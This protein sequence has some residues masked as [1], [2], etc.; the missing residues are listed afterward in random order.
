MKY[1]AAL[2]IF[3]LTINNSPAQAGSCVSKTEM[4]IAKSLAGVGEC[5]GSKK[6]AFENNLWL[7]VSELT[8]RYQISKVV[9]VEDTCA[10]KVL[11]SQTFDETITETKRFLSSETFGA[12]KHYL[13]D[14]ETAMAKCEA[15][16]RSLI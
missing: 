5:A 2:I 9:T 7:G 14:I 15:Y 16:R 1:S 11:L 12:K 3:A 4:M 6:V 8:V 13:A 10:N